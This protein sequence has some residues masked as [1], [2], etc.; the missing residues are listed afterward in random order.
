[1]RLFGL[2]ILFFVGNIAMAQNIE[3]KISAAV[4][5]LEND[6]QLKHAIF[7][8]YIVDGK[9]GK[10]VFDKNSQIGLATASCLKVVTSATAFELLGK[11][12]RF[13]TEIGYDG[14]IEND[15]LKG[16]L[17]VTSYGDPSFGSFRWDS[18][19]MEIVLKNIVTSL[20]ENKIKVITG[21]LIIDESKWETQATP[22]GWTWE[23]MGN[24]YG[25]G[26]RALNWNEN[27]Y[28]ILLKPG[29][30]EGDDVEI[31]STNPELLVSRL[32]NEL[33][34]GSPGSGDNSI[35]YLPEDGNIAYIRGTVPAGKASFKVSGAIPNASLSF[36]NSVQN[37]FKTQSIILLGEAKTSKAFA[38]NNEKMPSPAKALLNI[39]SP[40]L[41]SINYWFLQKSLNLFGEA[42]V[43]T[44]A[45]EKNGF[46]AT[47]TGLDIIEDFWLKNGIEK[48]AL[49]MYDGS[50]LSPANRVTTDALVTVMQFAKKQ[51]WYASFYDALPLQNNIKMKS[52]YIGGVRSYTGYVKS[53]SGAEYT[54]SFIINNYD[55]SSGA[56]REKMWKLL[57]ILKAP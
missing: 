38:F 18:T 42:F 53:K 30:K 15:T 16:N 41:D 12:Y 11:D 1:M 4:K 51:K 25:A 37:Y 19:N 57:D 28:D 56:V 29:K 36:I 26:A 2:M 27:Q 49:H 45:Y 8:L 46:G 23:D 50:G 17:F 44:I 55:G 13:K 43:K 6:S 21:S 7:S 35:I 54:F 10:V 39:S 9:T 22:G 48:S 3:T 47:K 31:T 14:S 33:K 40:S 24:Y 52:G 32:V 34:A 5:Q 20:K